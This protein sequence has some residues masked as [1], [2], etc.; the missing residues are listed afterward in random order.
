MNKLLTIQD[1][2]NVLQ[3][4]RRTVT[5]LIEEGKLVAHDCPDPRVKESD[6][7]QYIEST[8]RITPE[9]FAVKYIYGKKKLA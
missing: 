9:E 3:V 4:S 2:M 5:R 6:L 1:V 7:M 8:K